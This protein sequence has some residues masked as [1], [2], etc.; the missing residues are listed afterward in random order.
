MIFHFIPHEWMVFERGL[1]LFSQVWLK[2]RKE[3]SS[4]MNYHQEVKPI[5]LGEVFIPSALWKGQGGEFFP[6]ISACFCLWFS[7]RVQADIAALL[8]L[9]HVFELSFKLAGLDTINFK[10]EILMFDSSWCLPKPASEPLWG[11]LENWSQQSW[12]L[13]Q[14]VGRGIFPVQERRHTLLQM[15]R[16]LQGCNNGETSFWCTLLPF[17]LTTYFCILADSWK[18]RIQSPKSR[19]IANNSWPSQEQ[20]WSSNF[21]LG[22][23]PL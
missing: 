16:F 23:R 8:Y 4:E 3:A 18:V 9:S 22:K 15:H 12:S 11:D 1:P 10:A 20:T 7:P 14:P 2:K 6:G 19:A 5:E 13:A 21:Y 17:P